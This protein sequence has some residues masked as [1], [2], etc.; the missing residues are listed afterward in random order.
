MKYLF[1]M[2]IEMSYLAIDPQYSVYA[3]ALLAQLGEDSSTLF[4]LSFTRQ[5]LL[6]HSVQKLFKFTIY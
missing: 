4:L 6:V 2:S 1:K 5:F 3:G